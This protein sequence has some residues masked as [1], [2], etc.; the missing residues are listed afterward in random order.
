MSQGYDYIVVGG[1]SSGAPLAARLSE[2]GDARVLLLEAG[3]RPRGLDFKIP[4]A[5]TKLWFSPAATWSYMTEPE[6]GLDGR[7]LPV[8]RGRVL[9]GTSAINGMVVTRGAAADYDRWE[10]LG[11]P[12]WSYK[13]VLP[14]FKRV[15]SNWRGATPD[16]GDHGPLPTTRYPAVSPYSPLAFAAAEAMGFSATDDFCGPQPEGFGFPDFNI[17]RGRRITSAD[18]YLTPARSRPNLTVETGARVLRVLIEDGRA[19]GVEMLQD[20]QTRT[21]RAEHE[22]L[23]CGGAIA[24]PQ[25]L[26]LSGV[27]GADELKLAGVAPVVDLPGVGR[28]LEDQ[29]A[30]RFALAS[31][32]SIGFQS[33]LRADR[34]ALSAIR[35]FLFG[36]GPLAALPLL[37][38]FIVRTRPEA[39]QPDMRL[40]VGAAPLE[41]RIWFPGVRTPAPPVMTAAFSLCHPKS[42]GWVKLASADPLAQPRI[43]F[44]LLTDPE[45]LAEM[46]RGYRMMREML[47]QPTLALH[48]REMVQPPV[49]PKTDDE[50]DAYLRAM[51][52]TTFHPIGSCRMGVGEDAVVDGAFRVR[53]VEGLRVVDT[54]VFPTQIGGNPNVPAMMIAE[55][56]ADLIL[57]RPAP[58]P[59]LA[60]EPEAMP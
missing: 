46:R 26:L 18:A 40:M 50:I 13:D 12:G 55:K 38:S 8:P 23:L 43:A 60:Q 47:R 10:S 17:R 44:N 58:A 3:P 20:G 7:R 22:V 52:A 30:A 39:T 4:V 5:L 16:H 37:A 27:G 53:G 41:S 21:V 45:D 9:G 31:D 11:L 25:L 28:E 42:R 19:V 2:G 34:V 33:Q 57:G 56:A 1:G 35:W 14:Y 49:E 6:P 51:A 48:A 29:P 24:S 54:S 15:E 36:T 59:E 32:P